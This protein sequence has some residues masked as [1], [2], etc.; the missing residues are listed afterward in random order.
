[1]HT[2]RKISPTAIAALTALL[3]LLPACEPVGDYIRNMG[4]RDRRP[5]KDRLNE[6]EIRRWERDL[7]LSRARV[8][9]LNDTIQEMVQESNLQG[10]LSWKI[11]K[12]YL[13]AGRFDLAAQ[14]YE[15]AARNERLGEPA[16]GPQTF[17][18]AIPRFREAL[19]RH[20]PDQEL[21]YEAGLCFANSSRALGWEVERWRTAQYLFETALRQKPDDNRPRFQLALLY[22][23]T[24][25]PQV[26]NTSLAIEL[27]RE[28]IDREGDHIS[29][30]FALANIL[31]ETGAIAEAV[32]EYRNIQE[33]LQNLHRRGVIPGSL[34]NN[35][36]YQQTQE[37]IAQLEACLRGG[38]ECPYV[39]P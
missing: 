19:T 34:Q 36:P 14:H 10:M 38:A 9:E 1:M 32:E 22:G 24:E 39:A 27:L 12:A 35:P 33:M 13:E 29:A 37:N 28:I 3:F 21:I 17:E 11:G 4:E 5:P 20:Q 6:E 31:V 8:L 30:R 15:A 16:P 26:R 25:N 23:K 7:N 18:Q 2:S